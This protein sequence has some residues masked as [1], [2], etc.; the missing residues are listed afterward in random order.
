[1]L[2]QLCI[3]Y[4]TQRSTHYNAQSQCAL[5]SRSPVESGRDML[6]ILYI[7]LKKLKVFRAYVHS[8]FYSKR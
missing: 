1:M 7:F 6:F 4:Y 8:I 5:L 2:K 3:A